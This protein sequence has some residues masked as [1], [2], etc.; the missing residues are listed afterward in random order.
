MKYFITAFLLMFGASV[1][2]QDKINPNFLNHLMNKDYHKEVVFLV[3]KINFNNFNP[4][5]KD[6]LHFMRGWS[7]YA[8]KQLSRSA[9]D[10]SKVGIKSPFYI[11][12]HFF[13]AYNYF[14][15]GENKKAQNLLKE[16]KTDKKNLNSLRYFEKAGGAL[17]NRN[18]KKFRNEFSKVDTSY[19]PIADE[20]GKLNQYAT[21]LGNHK[22]KSPFLAG[23]MSAIIPGSGKIYAGKTGEGISSL[24]TVTGLG[25]VTWEN[26]NKKGPT[27]VKTLIFGSIFS[28]FYIGN[29][30]GSVFSVKL[31]EDEFQKMY[32]NKIL[33]N[34]HIPLRNVFN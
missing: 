25:L 31:A 6:S 16:I 3:D 19:Y 23:M 10:L 20:S 15:I 33:F 27:N 29:I 7:L 17:L 14:Y 9:K 21:K 13:A 4:S 2:S 11:K 34:I 22:P 30:Y 32:D 1:F 8:Q 18:F 12:S 28:A 26:Y 5:L 24:I